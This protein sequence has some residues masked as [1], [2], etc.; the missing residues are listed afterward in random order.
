MTI[1]IT[2]SEM[3]FGPYLRDICFHIEASNTYNRIKQNVKMAEFLLLKARIRKPPILL[4]VEAKT[5]APHPDNTPDFTEYINEIREKLVNAFSLY[6]ASRLGRHNQA[7][8][9]LPVGYR[10]LELSQVEVRLVLVIKNL[11]GSH[12]NDVQDK[13]TKALRPAVKTWSLGP[14]PVVVLNEQGAID[15]GLVNTGQTTP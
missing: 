5:S 6:W 10:T 12:L 7:K 13:L 2:E 14:T 9:E 4:I 11:R 3:N 15:K 8:A 1:T